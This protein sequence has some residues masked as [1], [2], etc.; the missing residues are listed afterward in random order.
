MSR[1]LVTLVGFVIASA[2]A[3]VA[4]HFRRDIG[5]A[6]G[7]IAS[8]SLLLRTPCGPIEYAEVGEGPAVLIVHGAGGGFDQGIAF[9]TELANRGLRVVAMSRFGYLRTPMPADASAA[10]Q[11][12]AHVC[13]PLLLG[14][15]RLCS[16]PHNV[17]TDVEA[18]WHPCECL[19]AS[20]MPFGAQRFSRQR[21][22]LL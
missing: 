7:R 4:F 20:K 1:R 19:I 21:P 3:I 16:G 14:G 2:G 22:E 8:G 5:V 9:G 15:K 13:L 10:A 11:A 18:L 12:D 6:Y 17:L